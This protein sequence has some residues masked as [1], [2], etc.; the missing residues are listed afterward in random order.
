M[1]DLYHHAGIGIK[2]Q[3]ASEK[4]KEP[5]QLLDDDK[6]VVIGT[7]SNL[8]ALYCAIGYRYIVIYYVIVLNKSLHGFL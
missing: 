5:L 8:R 3:L 6:N 7:M 1:H 2:Q 4:F